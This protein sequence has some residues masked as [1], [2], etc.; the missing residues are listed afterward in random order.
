M[1]YLSQ[2]DPRWSQVKLGDSTLTLG[3]YGCTTTCISMLSDYFKCFVYPDAIARKSSNYTKDGL[4][5]WPKLKFDKM[6][7]EWRQYGRDD[8]RIQESLSH[9]DKAVIVQVDN[10]EHWLV[11]IGK[12]WFGLGADW[13]CVDPWTGKKCHAIRDYHNITGSAHFKRV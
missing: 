3:G 11:V 1:I 12:T 8:R 6:A 4:I 7:F 10:G 5:L 9:P 2:R 13:V